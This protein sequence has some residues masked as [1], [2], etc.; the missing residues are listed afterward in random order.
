[1]EQLKNLL[2]LQKQP[3]AELVEIRPGR[4]VSRA[5]SQLGNCHMTL[6]AFAEG[7]SVSEEC[8]FG[9][10]LYY[11]LQGEMP[12]TLEQEQHLLSAGECMA[13]PA[14]VPHAIG[15]S[16]PFKLLQITLQDP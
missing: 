10:T 11:V 4:V 1:M 8:Y 16:K 12:L 2:P 15:G 5:L 7:E 13:I 6:L 14:G 3:L 9:D